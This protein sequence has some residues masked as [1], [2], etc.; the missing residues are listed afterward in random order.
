MLAVDEFEEILRYAQ[1]RTLA[2]SMIRLR[3]AHC[4]ILLK[5]TYLLPAEVPGEGAPPNVPAV[6][7][8]CPLL[9]NHHKRC[10]WPKRQLSSVT[11]VPRRKFSTSLNTQATPRGSPAPGVGAT[12]QSCLHVHCDAPYPY[13]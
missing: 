4:P 5:G 10:H 9:P 8:D 3:Y 13:P 2:L 1:S 7:L 12:G 6:E 11:R